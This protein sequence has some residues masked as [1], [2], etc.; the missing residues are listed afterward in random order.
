MWKVESMPGRGSSSPAC[1]DIDR[2]DNIVRIGPMLQS[3]R[4]SL[5]NPSS[6]GRSSPTTSSD[7][8][9]LTAIQAEQARS[10]QT[11]EDF[12]GS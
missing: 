4:K 10:L 5:N 2:S 11:Q 6:G 9:A 8:I 7:N 3:L 12:P 1:A